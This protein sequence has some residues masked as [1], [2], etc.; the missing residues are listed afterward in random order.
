[1][2]ASYFQKQDIGLLKIVYSKFIWFVFCCSIV[3]I[4]SAAD[5]VCD[6]VILG[7]GDIFCRYMNARPLRDRVH[8]D[9]GLWVVR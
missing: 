9:G 7:S 4:V 2:F 6:F 8:D 1:M 5:S 3:M